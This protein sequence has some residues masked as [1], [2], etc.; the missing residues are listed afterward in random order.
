MVQLIEKSIQLM[1]KMYGKAKEQRRHYCRNPG[2]SASGIWEEKDGK[3][4]AG[5]GGDE[6][7]Q[8]SGQGTNR[9]W[10]K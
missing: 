2:S 5:M 1:E 6:R 4:E 7:C 8:S 10:R 3:R 9:R